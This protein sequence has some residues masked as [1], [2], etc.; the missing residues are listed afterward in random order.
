MLIIGWS[1]AKRSSKGPRQPGSHASR[2]AAHTP[3]CQ[4]VLSTPT[5]KGQVLEIG[6]N[7]RNLPAKFIRHLHTHSTTPHHTRS[8][9]WEFTANTICTNLPSSWVEHQGRFITTTPHQEPN[10]HQQKWLLNKAK[11]TQEASQAPGRCRAGK[12]EQAK[13]Q[14]GAG[15]ATWGGA[16]QVLGVL[17]QDQQIHHQHP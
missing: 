1:P 3:G 12:E 5:A 4:G 6:Q 10:Q 13:H 17:D 7:I 8:S 15:Q 9:L 11:S 16:G 2:Q 14:G